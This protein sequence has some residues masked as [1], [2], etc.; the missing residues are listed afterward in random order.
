MN[1]DFKIEKLIKKSVN[2]E[3]LGKVDFTICLNHV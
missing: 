2:I 1:K 3:K